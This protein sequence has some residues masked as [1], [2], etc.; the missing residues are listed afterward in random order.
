MKKA[1]LLCA[2]HNDL[3]L[4]K[5]LKKLGFFIIA[6]GNKK[7]LPG[8]K[9]VD[10][11]ILADYSDVEK[12]LYIAKSEKV[13]A[14]VQ[15][16]NDYGVYTASYVA[17][18]LNLPG[19]DSYKTITTLHDKDR[20]K[21]FCAKNNI[22]SVPSFGFVEKQSALEWAKTASYPMIVKPVDCSAGNGIQKI[23]NYNEA[24][25]AIELAFEKSRAGRIIIERF[26]KG[27]QHGF[28]TF[29]KD[30]KVV[31]F[32]SNN[33]YSFENLYRVEIDTFPA[34]NEKLYAPIIIEQIEKIAEKLHLVDG[35]FHLQYIVENNKPYIIEVMR[36]IAGNMYGYP[37]RML[38]QFNWDYWETRARCGLSLY[39]IPEKTFS[40]GFYAYK[41]ILASNNGIIKSVNV[42][43]KY[44]RYIWDTYMVMKPGEIITNYLKEPVG[45]LFMMFSSAEEMKKVL[46]EDYET[47]FVKVE[48]EN[49]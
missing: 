28:S 7:G 4:V 26:I 18:K 41:T 47:G 12:I 14:I 1:L 34:D 21:D 8:E 49:A 25:Q 5:S 37:A 29:L 40:E 36:R 24:E 15:C 48:E 20:F 27:T 17:E 16:C 35:M 42:P 45:F 43:Q 6:T 19:Y 39:M 9:Y 11:F 2:S 32:C 22:L 10:K 13:D 30:E 3:D 44:E 38:T 23:S 31:A 46:I 33:E